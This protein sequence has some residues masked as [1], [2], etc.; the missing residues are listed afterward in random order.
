MAPVVDV[1]FTLAAGF[2]SRQDF[3]VVPG[4]LDVKTRSLA[5]LR[6]NFIVSCNVV[7]III[8]FR[9]VK[10]CAENQI[11]FFDRRTHRRST[12]GEVRVPTLLGWVGGKQISYDIRLVTCK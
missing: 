5:T 10:P 2:L 6:E 9:W 1:G 3:F 11:I 8:F 12:G 7:I 4:T